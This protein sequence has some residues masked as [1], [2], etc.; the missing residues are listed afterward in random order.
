MSAMSEEGPVYHLLVGADEA[1]L[2]ARA[3]HLLISDE[4]HQ[5]LIRRLAREVLAELAEGPRSSDASAAASS[6]A[7]SAPQ[8]KILHTSLRLL[9]NDL[10]HGQQGERALVRDLLQ[11]LPDEHSIRAIELPGSE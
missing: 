2:A 7:L 11:K 4:A 5:P 6:V 8:M 9:A 10:S 3:L 1:P